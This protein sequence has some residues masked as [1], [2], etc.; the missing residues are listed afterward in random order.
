[1]ELEVLVPVSPP[2]VEEHPLAPRLV[3]LT[4][5]RLGF[6]SNAKANATALLE[7]VAADLK[8]SVGSFET[9]VEVKSQGPTVAAPED[10]M[11]RLQR[12]EAVILAIAD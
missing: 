8:A 10:V 9:F 3:G 7:F 5:T 2:A 1:M 11:R 6:L 12:C 4:G